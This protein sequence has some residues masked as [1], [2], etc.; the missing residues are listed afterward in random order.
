MIKKFFLGFR[1]GTKDFGHTLSLIINS[2]MLSIVYII[3]VGA[4]FIIS[5]IFRKRFLDMQIAKKSKSYWSNL[6]LKRKN[7]WEYYRQ[8]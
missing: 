1:K 8:F 5:R 6:N 3:A 7:I 4:T 2:L